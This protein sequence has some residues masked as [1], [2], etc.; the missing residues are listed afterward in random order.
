MATSTKTATT[1]TATT[2]PANT[3]AG[4][5]AN[6]GSGALGKGTVY[7]PTATGGTYSPAPGLLAHKLP[8]LAGKTVPAAVWAAMGP[9]TKGA[10]LA[11]AQL[12]VQALGLRGA[13]PVLR[14]LAR[15]VAYHG[16]TVQ[17]VG[18]GASA[19]YSVAGPRA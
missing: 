9:G 15:F 16:C 10:T 12:Q 13:H 8:G 2:S 1:A 6:P 5:T 4:N 3:P 7:A 11:S 17:V 18:S 19:L 14:M